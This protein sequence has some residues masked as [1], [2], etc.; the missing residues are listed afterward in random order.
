MFCLKSD[1]F[2]NLRIFVKIYQDRIPVVTATSLQKVRELLDEY[3]GVE[4][5]YG[6]F[7]DFDKYEGEFPD[8]FEGTY[9]YNT[10]DGPEIFIQYCVVIDSLFT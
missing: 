3:V 1:F 8:I 9:K 7:I 6:E 2:K 5:G 4:T 10:E